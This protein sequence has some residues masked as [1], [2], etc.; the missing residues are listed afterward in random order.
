MIGIVAVKRA[1]K[2]FTNICSK[3]IIYTTA[4]NRRSTG[5]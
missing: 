3:D 2:E 1:K 5:K 4:K